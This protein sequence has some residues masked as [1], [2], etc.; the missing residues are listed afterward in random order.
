MGRL[1][2][3]HTKLN[4]LY[5]SLQCQCFLHEAAAVIDQSYFIL[6]MYILLKELE[7]VK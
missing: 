7:F 5:K 6:S 3:H 4:V 2:G 1:A